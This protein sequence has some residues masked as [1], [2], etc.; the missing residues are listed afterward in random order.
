MPLTCHFL[1]FSPSIAMKCNVEESKNHARQ[2]ESETKGVFAGKEPK[3]DAR[4]LTSSATRGV[5]NMLNNM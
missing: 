2:Y 1:V 5:E 4:P 3:Q